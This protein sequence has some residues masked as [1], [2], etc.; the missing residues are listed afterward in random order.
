MTQESFAAVGVVF[1]GLLVIGLLAIGI[2]ALVATLK[3]WLQEKRW[4]TKSMLE[5]QT[6]LMEA[7]NRLNERVNALEEHVG[8]REEGGRE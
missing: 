3:E 1:T 2:G 6:A 4:S 7:S 5:T 8:L